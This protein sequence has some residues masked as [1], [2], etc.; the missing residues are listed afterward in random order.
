MVIEISFTIFFQN[1]TLNI[2]LDWTII[3]T[4]MT[5]RMKMT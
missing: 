1:L 2:Y 4:G 3:V 5:Y